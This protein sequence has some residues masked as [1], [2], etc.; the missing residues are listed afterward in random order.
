M[1]SIQRSLLYWDTEWCPY[2]RGFC[3]SEVCN[4]EVPLYVLVVCCDNHLGCCNM[5]KVRTTSTY[6]CT[7][8]YIYV[9]AYVCICLCMCIPCHVW[10]VCVC[11]YVRMY[12][13]VY[14]YM[15]A[16]CTYTYVHR[17]T[18]VSNLCIKNHFYN[19]LATS[20]CVQM[21]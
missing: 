21:L 2:Y 1:P 19:T 7:Y 8:K 10:I 14:M 3:N 17:Y 15:Y 5:W 9:C 4:R 16:F 12:V 11:T 20:V 13:G 6:V 18:Y